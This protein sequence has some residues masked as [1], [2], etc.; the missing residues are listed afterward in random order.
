MDIGRLGDSG[1]FQVA[2]SGNKLFSIYMLTNKV[3]GESYIGF[4]SNY[5]TRIHQHLYRKKGKYSGVHRTKLGQAIKKYGSDSFD[6]CLLYQGW[7]KNY[8]LNTVEGLLI[9]EYNTLTNGY[10]MTIGGSGVNLP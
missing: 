10:N 9:K 7:D 4:D 3:T 8:V 5:P 6:Y 1:K 2:Y